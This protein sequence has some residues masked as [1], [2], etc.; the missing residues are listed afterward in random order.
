MVIL[1]QIVPF[2]KFA[3]VYSPLT[4]AAF[5]VAYLTGPLFGGVINEHGDWRWVFLLKFVDDPIG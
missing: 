3:A 5:S 1:P 2:P 4:A